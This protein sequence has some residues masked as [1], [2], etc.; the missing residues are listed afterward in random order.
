VGRLHRLVYLAGLPRGR[1]ESAASQELGGRWAASQGE[2]A[3]GFGSLYSKFR[4]AALLWRRGLRPFNARDAIGL[5]C[6][7]CSRVCVIVVCIYTIV[8]SGQCG[9]A[10]GIVCC[11]CMW[12]SIAV[13][14]LVV[15]CC[16]K[17]ASR[18][19][20]KCA[21]G[22]CL[23]RQFALRSTN[24]LHCV[25]TC[26]LHGLPSLA[27]VCSYSCPVSLAQSGAVNWFDFCVLLTDLCSFMCVTVPPL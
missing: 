16:L 6:T 20:L 14:W 5:V 10:A 12:L 9:N 11:Y 27:A 4:P 1:L 25:C 3:V 7:A 8:C 19:L 2:F 23:I 17:T 24:R 22:Q 26:T 18:N 13:S 15:P 21:T